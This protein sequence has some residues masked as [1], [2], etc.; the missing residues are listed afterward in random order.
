MKSLMN[1]RA[2]LDIQ[3]GEKV[4]RD[5]ILYKKNGLRKADITY[6]AL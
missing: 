4:G 3:E 1:F 2:K 5:L 6:Q